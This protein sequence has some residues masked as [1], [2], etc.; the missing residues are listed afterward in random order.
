MRA[1]DTEDKRPIRN[2]LVV[3]IVFNLMILISILFSM[4]IILRILKIGYGSVPIIY[5]PLLHHKHSK[6]YTFYSFSSTG[7]YGNF[8]VHYDDEGLTSNPFATNKKNIM[9]SEIR[10]AFM[11]DSYIEGMQVKYNEHVVGIL[12]QLTKHNTVIKNYG[13]SSYSPILNYLQWKYE[14]SKFKPTL[15]I[16][17]LFSND[18]EGDYEMSKKAIYSST[19]ELIAIPGPM[20][21]E[22]GR[23]SYALRFFNK[24]Y[25]IIIYNLGNFN[26]KEILKNPGGFIEE[27]PNI[28]E[29]SSNLILKLEKAISQSGGKLILM[30]VPSKYRLQGDF[31]KQN[32]TTLEFSDKWKI[33][34]RNY[35]IAFIDLVE[36][37]HR[38]YSIK[39]KKLFFDKEIHFNAE[40]HKVLAKTIAQAF[41]EIFNVS[42]DLF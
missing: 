9:N 23:K 7:E 19:N 10:I 29:L 20:L 40:G 26:S 33:W 37:F 12:E 18:I 28:T 31:N 27:N 17:L 24:F 35:G 32:N 36:A 39:G 15:V 4:E 13:V 8:L 22:L 30:V 16:L 38:E 2:H 6:N 5:D 41:P 42:A 34:A 25:K 11:G 14:V 1:K 21:V 3:L